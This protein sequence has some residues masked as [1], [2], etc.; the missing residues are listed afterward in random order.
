[1]AG[2]G[3]V[4]LRC[5]RVGARSACTG[6]CGRWLARSWRRWSGPRPSATGATW[7]PTAW[8]RCWPVGGGTVHARGKPPSMSRPPDF[9]RVAAVYPVL[10]TA[11]AFGWMQ[12][13]RR[14]LAAWIE[15]SRHPLL[16]GE[17]PGRL[18]AALKRRRP[19]GPVTVVDASGGMLRRA[20]RAWEREGGDADDVRFVHADLRV[21]SPPA[22]VHDAVAL[23]FVL[24][25]FTGP[26][27]RDVAARFARGL[28]EGGCLVWA[29]FN[30]PGGW[31]AFPAR[32][33]IRLLYAFFGVATGLGVRRL[34]DP[35][36]ALAAA[37]L[38]R[39]QARFLAGGLL[40][41]ERWERG[42]G[43]P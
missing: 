2:W 6:W 28:P 12:R 41:V 11:L 20:R 8:A 40:R 1:M 35:S 15:D 9:D 27:L 32:A 29:D 3:G 36:P 14:V 30:V 33:L 42:T 19:V 23:P 34:E 18:L 26:E 16:A 5:R 24:D 13:A 10:E 37:G 21:W 17:G 7:S 38:R 31:R 22:G 25:C 43:R 39:H 4:L